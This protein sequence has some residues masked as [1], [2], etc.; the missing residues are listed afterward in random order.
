MHVHKSWWPLVLATMS[1]SLQCHR[2]IILLTSCSCELRDF[3]LSNAQF[4]STTIVL[5]GS[6]NTKPLAM[7]H[8]LFVV[9][10]SERTKNN[11]KR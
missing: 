10:K 4:H 2:N 5:H 6:K 9:Y 3:R 7:F 8:H 1:W 11:I